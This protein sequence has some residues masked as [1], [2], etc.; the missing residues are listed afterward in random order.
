LGTKKVLIIGGGTAGMTGALD[1]A[2]RG[3]E[4]FLVDRAGNIGGRA[5]EYCCKATGACNH[6]SVCLVLQQRER[7]IREPMIQVFCSAS[8]N[9]ILKIDNVFKVSITA[10]GKDMVLECQAV[11]AATGFDPYDLDRRREFAYGV[12]KN[13]ISGLDLELALRKKGSMIAAFGPDINKIGFVQCVG[14]RDLTIGNGYCSSVCCMYAARLARLIRSELPDALLNIFY[15]DFQGFGKGFADFD[16]GLRGSDRVNFIRAIPSKIYGFP[17][18]H[19][20][21]RYADSLSGRALEDKYDLIVLSL[22][23]TPSAGN[24]DLAQKLGIGLNEYGF[25]AVSSDRESLFT[26]QPGIFL[27]GVCQGPKDIPQTIGHATA[28]AGEAYRFLDV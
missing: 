25:L 12:E 17:Y 9:E 21:V 5:A 19:L 28:A 22:A 3:V 20:T 18:D 6:C 26:S 7:V 24:K 23:I 2:A 14:S 27:A 15:M 11:I 8:I 10:P 4:V 1:L 13:V 16:R